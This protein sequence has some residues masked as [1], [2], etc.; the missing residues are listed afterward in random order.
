M[1]TASQVKASLEYEEMLHQQKLLDEYQ[2]L[3]SPYP[4]VSD[5][6]PFVL[7]VL[8]LLLCH[9]FALVDAQTLLI[10]QWAS[11]AY[12]VVCGIAMAERRRTNRR[13]DLL[14]RIMQHQLAARQQ[15]GADRQTSSALAQPSPAAMTV[16]D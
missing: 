12:F 11:S 4:Q 3:G 10:V 8:A 15:N 7:V 5:L 2:R 14:F 16:G 9:Q 13:I 6:V 1:D